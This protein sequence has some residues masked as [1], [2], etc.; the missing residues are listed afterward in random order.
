MCQLGHIFK[1]PSHMSV[2]LT[3]LSTFLKVGFRVPAF[4]ILS[5]FG[6]SFVLETQYGRVSWAKD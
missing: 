6:S 2:C 5:C 1:G 4:K 3:L